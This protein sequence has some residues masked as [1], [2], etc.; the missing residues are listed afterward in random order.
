MLSETLS[1]RFLMS[2]LE[3]F[4]SARWTI[5]NFEAAPSLV[6]KYSIFDLPVDMLGLNDVFSLSIFTQLF[7]LILTLPI[8]LFR[9]LALTGNSNDIF[10]VTE[11]STFFAAIDT[12]GYSFTENFGSLLVF[13]TFFGSAVD[14]EDSV[15]ETEG[16]DIVSE[17]I[18]PI[19]LENLGRRP[20]DNGGLFT[21][22]ATLF[23][24]VFFCNLSGMVP[25]SDTPT[26][27]LILTFF[28]AVGVFLSINTIMVRRN[29]INYFFSLFLPSGAPIALILLLIPIEFI[30]YCFRAVSLAVRLFA[31]MMAGHTLFKVL[32]GFSWTLFMIGDVFLLVALLPIL[33]LFILTFLEIGIA[34]VQAYIFTVLTCMYFKDVF[35]AH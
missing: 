13:A 15:L 22:I 5:F 10:L 1:M 21:N 28:L 3:Q 34:V 30:S 32:I 20:T 26:S 33:V 29:G 16:D 17:I 9:L 11:T 27:S 18:A 25:Y 23:S 31:N 4:D 7:L 12:S 2:P 24:F 35:Q 14:E 19:F 8:A 6:L